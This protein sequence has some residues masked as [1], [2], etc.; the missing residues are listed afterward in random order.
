MSACSPVMRWPRLSLVEI[1]TV[2]RQ[3]AIASD[4]V[5]RVGRGAEEVAAQPDEDLHP[6]VVHRLRWSSRCRGRAS[7][8]GAKPNS[9]P[10]ASRNVGAH[11]LPDAH[12]A[13]ALHVAV[14][15]HRTEAGAAPPDLPAQEREVDD[16]LHVGDAVFVLGDAHR[17]AADHPLRRDARSPPPRAMSSRE[18]PL[19]R[20][21]AS[22]DAASRSRASASN[23][24]VW[25]A[26]KS[27]ASSLPPR[28]AIGLEHLL[29]DPLQERDVAV[30]PHRQEQ[31]GD[32]RAAAEQRRAAPA[33]S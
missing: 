1:C 21:I 7:S 25:C 3:R 12:R 15:A 24:S 5:V 23:P 26:M 33:G 10:S 29:H 22:H 13:V 4:G 20:T 27:C 18:T 16:A 31:A 11:L 8:G 32:L 2:S 28:G 6:A 19:S 30:D 14:A 9:C 17:P